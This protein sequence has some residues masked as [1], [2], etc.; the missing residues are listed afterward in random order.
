MKSK[1]IPTP[2]YYKARLL[3]LKARQRHAYQIN[4][5]F[6]I[7]IIKEEINELQKKYDKLMI[8]DGLEDRRK[9]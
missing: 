5:E 8:P 1:F 2:M 3:A 6:L 4:D 9:K 7:I